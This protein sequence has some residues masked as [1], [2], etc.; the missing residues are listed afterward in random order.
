MVKNPESFFNLTKQDSPF[1]LTFYYVKGVFISS[2]ITIIVVE[3]I[4][5]LGSLISVILKEIHLYAY[6]KPYH[7]FAISF[8]S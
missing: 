1:S 3:S 4:L 5:L 7:N 8:L 2:I 6:R